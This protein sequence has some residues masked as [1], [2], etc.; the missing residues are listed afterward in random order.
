M[1]S[2]AIPPHRNLLAKF[3]CLG[4]SSWAIRDLTDEDNNG[5]ELVP[6]KLLACIATVKSA[7]REL[8]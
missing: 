1:G 4:Y 6:S 8:T 2:S 3:V 7:A 5:V